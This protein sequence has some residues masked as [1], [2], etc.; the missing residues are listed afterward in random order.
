MSALAFLTLGAALGSGL[1]AG[2][3]FAFSTFVMPALARLAP[4]QGVAAMQAINVAV[5]NRW[6]LGVFVGTAAAC[7]LLGHRLA[8]QVVTA[9]STAL[10]RGDA[11][12]SAGS[13][14]RHGG[15]QRSAQR[16]AG[17]RSAG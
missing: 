9:G 17:E 2:V 14:R 11:A 13:D 12:L 1:I 16:R 6:F 7:L 8:D 15:L 5:L 4:A 10:F 3:F